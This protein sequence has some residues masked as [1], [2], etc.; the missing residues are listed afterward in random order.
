MTGW[1]TQRANH[2][3]FLATSAAIHASSTIPARIGGCWLAGGELHGTT[4]TCPCHGTQFDVTFG[5]VLGGPARR[6]GSSRAV[7][8]EG[9][10]LLVAA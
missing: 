3:W 8:V 9:E 7:Q 5:A 2:N 6:P 10:D 4:L 1:G